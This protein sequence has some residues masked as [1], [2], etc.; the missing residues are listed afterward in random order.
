M[1]T[2]ATPYEPELKILCLNLFTQQRTSTLNRL[3]EDMR[4][5]FCVH[6]AHFL[7]TRFHFICQPFISELPVDYTFSK[8]QF[9]RVL[10]A[11][12]SHIG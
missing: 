2:L 1:G 11:I 12:I 3:M 10:H 5:L 6:E 7:T 9:S 8:S 4:S